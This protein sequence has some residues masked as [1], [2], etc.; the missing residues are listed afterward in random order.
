MRVFCDHGTHLGVHRF[1]RYNTQSKDMIYTEVDA[2]DRSEIGRMLTKSAVYAHPYL[3][4]DCTSA[5]RGVPSV[6]AL[7]EHLQSMGIVDEESKYE[8]ERSQTDRMFELCEEICNVYIKDAV[9]KN[10][11]IKYI[12]LFGTAELRKRVQFLEIYCGAIVTEQLH[13]VAEF[14]EELWAMRE[15]ENNRSPTGIKIHFEI[16]GAD[17]E[18][19]CSHAAA[20]D[21]LSRLEHEGKRMLQK[22]LQSLRDDATE[23]FSTVSWNDGLDSDGHCQG[24]VS[25]PTPYSIVVF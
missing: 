18:A 1:A 14:C 17:E 7:Q 4:N 5:H 25:C 21:G 23:S 9:E 10:P 12:L 20:K 8:A 11:S 3:M 2:P 24:V 13:A 22:L 19:L 16:L 15:R 6:A